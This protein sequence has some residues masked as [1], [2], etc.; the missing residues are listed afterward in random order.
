M[1]FGKYYHTIEG[2]GR[3]SLPA[4]FRSSL[5][6]S[7]IVTKGLD[8]CLFVFDA[9][10]WGKK[11]TALSELSD[12]K[13]AHREY[14]RHIASNAQDAQIDELGRIRIDE[15]LRE[16]VGLARKVVCVG[17]LDHIELWD[18]QKYRD[19]SATTAQHIEDTIEHIGIGKEL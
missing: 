11:L 17:A 15:E 19:Y 12:T 2:K 18:T 9:E 10:T 1:Y 13:R 5:G 8:G 6:E 4:A 7:V 14:V 3:L 16:A